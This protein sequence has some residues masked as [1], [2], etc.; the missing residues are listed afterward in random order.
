MVLFVT[1]RNWISTRKYLD[2]DIIQ[3]IKTKTWAFYPHDQIFSLKIT[4]NWT[5]T[6][7]NRG[8]DNPMNPHDNPL[9][10]QRAIE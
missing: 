5:F 10:A 3:L 7:L 6:S 8:L 4:L 2:S 9:M 1:M